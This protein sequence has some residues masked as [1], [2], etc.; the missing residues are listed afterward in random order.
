MTLTRQP[1]ACARRLDVYVLDYLRKRR[2]LQTAASF[3]S[4]AK[5]AEAPVGGAA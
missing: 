1:A 2:M 3:Q 4:E 5:L